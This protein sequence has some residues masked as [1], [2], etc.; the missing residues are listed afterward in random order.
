VARREPR[1][2]RA[3]APPRRRRRRLRMPIGA[4]LVVFLVA[5]VLLGGYYASQTV[6]FVGASNDGFVTVYRGLPYELPAGLDLYSVNYESGVPL[7]ELTAAQ[8]RTI[9]EHKLRSK[10]DAQDLVRQLETGEL[11][12]R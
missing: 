6:Y 7:D 11:A 4:I 9:T 8:R 10:D 2:G 12:R 1:A 3:A 5:C